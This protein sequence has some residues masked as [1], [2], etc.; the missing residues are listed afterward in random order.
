MFTVP[1]AA[2]QVAPVIVPKTP[3]SKASSQP[4]S[5][6]GEEGA[7]NEA[8]GVPWNAIIK[9]GYIVLFSVIS[10]VVLFVVYLYVTADRGDVADEVQLNQGN[11]IQTRIEQS[12]TGEK[13]I[14]WIPAKNSATMEGFKVKVHHV[15]WGKVRGKDE[16]GDI[17]ES[18]RPFVN[19]FLELANR[20]GNKFHFKSWYGNVFTA[21][22]G[23]SRTAQISDDEKQQYEPIL[24]DDLADL[25]WWTPSKTFEPLE[26]GTDSIVFDVPEDFDPK[27]VEFLFLD[28][29]G[30]AVTR[31]GAG[32]PM[33]GSYRFKIPRSM[34][35]GL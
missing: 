35:Q 6:E 15:L 1:Q 11:E 33:G 10:A 28:L 7:E 34:I 27:Q 24:F 5:T 12:E 26:E 14:K 19:V 16:R 23:A 31:D 30:E 22:N 32:K 25:K 4:T 13:Y 3:G 8:G 21:E 29:P 20:S 17:I 18:D 2:P 9:T